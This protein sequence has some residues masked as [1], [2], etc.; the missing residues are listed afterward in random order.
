MALWVQSRSQHVIAVF[1]AADLRWSHVGGLLRERAVVG[2]ISLKLSGKLLGDTLIILCR[3]GVLLL[4]IILTDHLCGA[5][6]DFE[7]VVNIH[8]FGFFGSANFL[9]IKQTS[10][11][12]V[13][14]IDNANDRNACTQLAEKG[15]ASL[16]SLTSHDHARAGGYFGD[17][18]AKAR[19][20]FGAIT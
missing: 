20:V 1:S 3:G 10:A 12:A 4:G 6:S 8:P 16:I 17:G 18:G 9:A 11:V 7:A 15:R 13:S 2:L 14:I 5:R 19:P